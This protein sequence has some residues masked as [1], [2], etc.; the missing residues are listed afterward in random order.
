MNDTKKPRR[1]ARANRATA[2]SLGKA[3]TDS[4]NGP[5]FIFLGTRTIKPGDIVAYR[6]RPRK[7]EIRRED[8]LRATQILLVVLN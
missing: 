6:R 1:P 8:I 3:P 4:K 5:Y 7:G 2:E